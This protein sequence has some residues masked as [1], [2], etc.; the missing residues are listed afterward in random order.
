MNEMKGHEKWAHDG[1]Q[2]LKGH[3]SEEDGKMLDEHHEAMIVDPKMKNL[4]VTASNYEPGSKP[5]DQIMK[6]I[7]GR[8]K[9]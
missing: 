8:I 9:K 1:F 4:L 3:V 6:H 7:K 5:L 2:N